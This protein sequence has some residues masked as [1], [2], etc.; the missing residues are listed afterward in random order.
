VQDTGTQQAVVIVITDTGLVTQA[1]H[2]AVLARLQTRYGPRYNAQN[3]LISATHTHAGPGG[4]SHYALYNIT[5]LGFQQ[6][7]FQAIVDG[8]VEAI[9]K[10][11]A[12]QAPGDILL[13]QGELHG[14]SRNRSA[15]AFRLNP[16]A[17][18]AAF[19]HEIDPLMSVLT[20]RQ[21]GKPVGAL[22]LFPTHGTSMTNA[23]TLISGDN[24]GYAA[25]HWEHEHAGVRYRNDPAPFVAAFAQTN[26]G[27]MSP[28]LNLRPGSGP[29]QD[30]V[31]N[32]RLIGLRQFDKALSLSAQ[33]VIS[34][35]GPV[36]VRMRY[37]DMSGVQVAGAYTPDGQV[38]TTCPAALGTSFAAGSEED[39]PGPG[40]AKEGQSN[41][42]LAAVGGLVFW[43]SEAL[44]QCHGAKEIVIPVGRMQPHPWVPE[45]LPLHLVRIGQL[46]LATLP[47][48]P[49]IMSGYRIRRQ[50]AA[51]LGVA[52]HQVLVLGYTNAYT[53]YITTPEE[54]SLQAYEGGST[55]F[56]PYTLPAYTQ[57]LDRLARDMA[58][59]QPTRNTLQ[60]R[61][62][63]NS[64]LNLQSGVVMD[65]PARGQ[66]FGSVLQDA[67]ARYAVGHTVRVRFQTGH[68]KNNL[69]RNGTFLEVQRLVNGQWQ[70]VAD[71]GDWS[72]RY[73]WVRLFAAE[74]AADISWAIPPG[75]PAGHYRIVHMGDAKPLFGRISAFTGTSR[76]FEVVAD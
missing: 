70:P 3:V 27:D 44:K 14:A 62:L 42:F 65:L 6:R 13:N 36:D 8:I 73:R 52:I 54:Y 45:V 40:V 21:G 68:P 31:E 15:L 48:E 56:G 57:E 30:E 67:A 7:T 24:K 17:D 43:P 10:A 5:I 41:P 19:P 9:D 53:E 37:V 2:Q 32:T 47:G 59:G 35:P 63:R 49:T 4:Y 66:R 11:H 1:M 12:A 29:T 16:A 72:T 33:A 22:S 50:L 39:G 58:A 46:Y 28:N 23:N 74:S 34:L 64:Q 38:H 69:H 51:T 60:P 76:T 61:D 18:R 20:F 26:P 25:Y 55:L 75:T 71:D